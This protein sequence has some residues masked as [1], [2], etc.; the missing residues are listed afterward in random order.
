MQVHVELLR[1]EIAKKKRDIANGTYGDYTERYHISLSHHW[2]NI[3][4]HYFVQSR[5]S[6]PALSNWL[7]Q[8][9]DGLVLLLYGKERQQAFTGLQPFP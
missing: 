8:T 7:Q 2:L 6:N 1:S 5:N 3:G 4:K 9:K